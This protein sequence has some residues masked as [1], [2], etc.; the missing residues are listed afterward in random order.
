MS[1]TLV[2][3]LA[4]LSP[5]LPSLAQNHDHHAAQ[6]VTPPATAATATP[7]SGLPMVDAE[8]RRV[9]AGAGKV[10]LKHGDIPNLEMPPMTMVFQVRD[11]AQ[12]G[13]LKAGD[14][15]RFTADKVN[16][17]YT[18]IELEAMP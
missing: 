8:V 15:V 9:D 17:A 14:K 13:K 18:V 11:L 12:L 6:A 3:A 4:L 16:G 1:K 5:A 2:L 10:T 7:A